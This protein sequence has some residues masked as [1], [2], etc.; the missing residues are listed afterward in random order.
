MKSSISNTFAKYSTPLIGMLAA[1]NVVSICCHEDSQAPSKNK[2]EL[3][4]LGLCGVTFMLSLFDAYKKPTIILYALAGGLLLASI[5]LNEKLKL[6]CG[7]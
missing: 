3:L 1:L 2:C 4:S 6:V 5:A 7:Q